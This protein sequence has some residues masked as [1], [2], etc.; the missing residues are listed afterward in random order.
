[1]SDPLKALITEK[2]TSGGD[3]MEIE[4]SASPS[5]ASTPTAKGDDGIT[6]NDLSI[7]A[8]LMPLQKQAFKD[9]LVQFHQLVFNQGQATGTDPLTSKPVTKIPKGTRKRRRP[10]F[11]EHL[12]SIVPDDLEKRLLQL[13][14]DQGGLLMGNTQPFLDL[15]TQA[16]SVEKRALFLTIILATDRE[17]RRTSLVEMGCLRI[18]KIWLIEAMEV[19]KLELILLLL[20][21]LKQLPV[22]ELALRNTEVFKPV[23]KCKKMTTA[24]DVHSTA[25]ALIDQWQ[26]A[27]KA[28]PGAA[29]PAAIPKKARASSP[30]TDTGL[31]REGSGDA[32]GDAL[33]TGKMSDKEKAN[34]AKQAKQKAEED[35][36]NRKKN[37][38]KGGS[39][40]KMLD[41]D[42]GVSSAPAKNRLGSSVGGHDG[43]APP[44]TL[45]APPA[46][47]PT[48]PI[49]PMVPTFN[50]F[51]ND[52]EYMLN[53]RARANNQQSSM[54][55]PLLD[56]LPQKHS[57]NSILLKLFLNSVAFT[58]PPAKHRRPNRLSHSK[59]APPHATTTRR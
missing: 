18:L 44:L 1:M 15:M 17:K 56:S 28:Q 21:T 8:K 37:R 50:Q 54:S 19:Q 55:A 36:M 40:L 58:N 11:D 32:L 4:D 5:D 42:G 51:N 9:Q 14:N 53:M 33:K 31:L 26:E 57:S 47:K 46:V 13:L 10:D 34:A 24:P 30:A 3:A 39:T 52:G 23:K 59:P 43:S 2:P 49:L 12:P 16:K 22:T 41:E 45:H 38:N 6:Q 25:T 7:F 29:K 27:M 35:K 20:E 48:M